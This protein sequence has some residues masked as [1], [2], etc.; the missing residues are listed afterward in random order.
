MIIW[1][2]NDHDVLSF[3][4]LI[5]LLGILLSAQVHIMKSGLLIWK[6]IFSRNDFS[7]LRVVERERE[8]Q[9]RGSKSE[10]EAA[11][12]R[13]R[14]R[15]RERERGERKRGRTRTWLRRCCAAKSNLKE[16]LVHLFHGR[17][18]GL[19]NTLPSRTF[20]GVCWHYVA[21]SMAQWRIVPM[22]VA[23]VAR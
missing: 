19:L 7:N 13:K 1:S 11:R 21:P 12:Q 4:I 20:Q 8:E 15:M 6:R 23:A 3:F 9:R 2:L 14:E 17:N 10:E 22:P 5:S 16:W 18:N